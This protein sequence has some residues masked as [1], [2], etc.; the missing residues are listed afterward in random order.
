SALRSARYFSD[1]SEPRLFG[2]PALTCVLAMHSAEIR[3]NAES[4][5]VSAR[6]IMHPCHWLMLLSHLVEAGS[7]AQRDGRPS[8]H[9]GSRSFDENTYRCRQPFGDRGCDAVA[10]AIPARHAA[11]RTPE[12]TQLVA[13]VSRPGLRALPGPACS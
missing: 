6:C 9:T 5:L 1:S 13:A 7:A 12:R 2:S 3:S 10:S 8:Q 4:R 11:L